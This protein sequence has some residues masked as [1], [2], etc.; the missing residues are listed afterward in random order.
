MSEDMEHGFRGRISPLGTPQGVVRG[1]I[2]PVCPPSCLQE[3]IPQALLRTLTLPPCLPRGSLRPVRV[4]QGVLGS[5]LE[6]QRL[7]LALVGN[8]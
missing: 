2:A 8:L 4:P 3:L 1:L 6:L 7:Y 5:C